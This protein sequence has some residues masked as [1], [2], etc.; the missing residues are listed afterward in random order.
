MEVA[1]KIAPLNVERMNNLAMAYL[2]ARQPDQCVHKMKQ[3]IQFHPEDPAYKFGLFGQLV[4]AGFDE[5]AQS[6][7]KET[8]NPREVVR[9]YNNYGVA[10]AK[11]G[12]LDEAIEEYKKCI[13][14]YPTFKEVYRIYYN[15][16]LAHAQKRKKNDVDFAID[17]LE[18]CLKLNPKFEKATKTKESLI[19]KELANGKTQEKV[20][21]KVYCC[22]PGYFS[23]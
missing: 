18:E 9:H 4:K 7:C 14:F 11:S 5:H 2:A 22:F 6:L 3:L 21:Q 17:A 19:G 8:S 10:L 16:A 13:L 1:D 23:F 15:L 20:L 12:K